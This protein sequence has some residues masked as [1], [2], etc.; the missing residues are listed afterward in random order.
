M[1]KHWQ[2]YKLLKA[3]APNSL[4]G[5][6]TWWSSQ[7]LL[8]NGLIDVSI[9]PDCAATL[10]GRDTAISE[11]SC[12]RSVGLFCAAPPFWKGRGAIKKP[13]LFCRFLNVLLLWGGGKIQTEKKPNKIA[14]LQRLQVLFVLVMFGLIIKTCCHHLLHSLTFTCVAFIVP[15]FRILCFRETSAINL[16]SGTLRA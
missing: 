12:R 8:I 3:R 10:L 15:L 13:W 7:G 14:F 9:I 11:L 6:F 5:S 1:I 2:I 4:F 16:S